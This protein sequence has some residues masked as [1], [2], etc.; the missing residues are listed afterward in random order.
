MVWE[1]VW[2]MVGRRKREGRKGRGEREGKGKRK[3]GKIEGSR[4]KL[5]TGS[6]HGHINYKGKKICSSVNSKIAVVAN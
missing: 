2:D 6:K 5:A 3:R 1:M 4:K